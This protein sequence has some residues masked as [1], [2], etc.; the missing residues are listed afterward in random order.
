[1]GDSF[2]YYTPLLYKK[3]TTAKDP[4]QS[5]SNRWSQQVCAC[6]FKVVER[7]SPL[8]NRALCK[9][10]DASFHPIISTHSQVR[11]LLVNND[12]VSSLERNTQKDFI[13]VKLEP[14][15]FD[16]LQHDDHTRL[17]TEQGLMEVVDLRTGKQ[18]TVNMDVFPLAGLVTNTL[19]T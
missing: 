2:V 9:V 18:L 10:L 6:L 13:Q 1:M 8:S 3:N 16:F 4:S 5:K 15:V 12:I 7:K 19:T 14:Y 11:D 17:D